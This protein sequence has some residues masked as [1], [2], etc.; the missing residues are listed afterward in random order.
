MKPM[1]RD[2]AYWRA[3]E[4][5]YRRRHPVDIQRNLAVMEALM[6]QARRLGAWQKRN[7]LEGLEVKIRIA[8]ILNGSKPART[9]GNRA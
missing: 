6:A 4:D 8:R 1:I 7:P 5:N 2:V 9:P 3:W